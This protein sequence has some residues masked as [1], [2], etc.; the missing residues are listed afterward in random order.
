MTVPNP[1]GAKTAETPDTE[2]SNG[3]LIITNCI[4]LIQFA[5]PYVYK[6]VQLSLYYMLINDST[7]S[8]RS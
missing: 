1:T 2:A 7:Q 4:D 5:D 3:E 8:H 6:I